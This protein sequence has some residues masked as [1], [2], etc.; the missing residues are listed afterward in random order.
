MTEKFSKAEFEAAL[1]KHKT[2]GAQLWSSRG[3]DKG[4]Y[5]YFVPVTEHAGIIIRSS[6]DSSGYAAS[7]GEDSIR[8]WLVDPNTDAPV[9]GKLSKYVTRVRGWQSRLEEQ[10]RTLYRIGRFVRPC[11]CG[12]TVRVGKSKKE[13]EMKGYLFAS[14]SNRECNHTRFAWIAD[15]KGNLVNKA[16]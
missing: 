7:T 6:V 13:N 1:P 11:T 9:G 2:T 8:M 15:P 12:G 5:V 10:L 3:F 4:E 16:A 14:C